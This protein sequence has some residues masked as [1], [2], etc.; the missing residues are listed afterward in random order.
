MAKRLP[1]WVKLHTEEENGPLHEYYNEVA[2]RTQ[3]LQQ[4]LAPYDETIDRAEELMANIDDELAALYDRICTLEQQK[5]ELEGVKADA[6]QSRAKIMGAHGDSLIEY[7]M[8]F[9]KDAAKRYD[10]PALADENK[11]WDVDL[12]YFPIF[13][14]M[15]IMEIL[16]ETSDSIV[17]DDD[18]DVSDWMGKINK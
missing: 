5:D 10:V 16:E 13:K 15:Y 6:H 18:S 1:V 11:N 7:N 9:F 12:A 4:S 17:P 3:A 14:T 2:D 8:G